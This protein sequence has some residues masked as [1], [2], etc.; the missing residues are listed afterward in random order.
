MIII[1]TDAEIEIMREA[2]RIVA[3][4]H[5][6]VRKAIKVG[7]STKE[8]ND[9]AAHVIKSYNAIPSFKGYNGFAGEICASVNDEVI[10][11]IPSKHK[12]L[13]DGDIVKIDIGALYKG[14]HGDSA[15][16]HTV[17]N[18]SS[19]AADLIDITKKSFYEAIQFAKEGYRLNDISSAVEKIVVQNGF[20]VVRDY[21]GHGVGRDLH[22]DPEVPNYDRKHHGP[23]LQKGMVLAIEPMINAGSAN[24][25]TLDDGWTVVT[26]DKSLS[27]HYEHTIAITDGEPIILTAL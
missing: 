5:D 1:K 21:V 23:R 12:I 24:V 4:A 22:E 27:A 13:A 17:G 14:Y 18:V 9:I 26:C 19:L 20:S 25:K 10:H 8:L 16:T 6:A 2:G 11:G 3:M 15:K 7:I